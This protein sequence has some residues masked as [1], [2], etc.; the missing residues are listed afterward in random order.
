MGT[1]MLLTDKRIKAWRKFQIKSDRKNAEGEYHDPTKP[2][3]AYRCAVC[4]TCLQGFDNKNNDGG[5][6]IYRDGHTVKVAGSNAG[7]RAAAAKLAEEAANDGDA[8]AAAKAAKK[9]TNKRNKSKQ[10]KEE[11]DDDGDATD[12]SDAESN[13]DDDATALR[14]LIAAQQMT[15]DCQN[16]LLSRDENELDEGV[17]GG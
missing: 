9:S 16:E 15:I 17:P 12:A 14:A 13:A 6:L 8:D 4:D 1:A 7:V 3:G 11:S 10:Q 5:K 2:W